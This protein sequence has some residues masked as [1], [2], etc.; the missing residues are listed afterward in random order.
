ML[1]V[2]QLKCRVSTIDDLRLYLIPQLGSIVAPGIQTS[3]NP[4]R[5]YETFSSILLH[6]QRDSEKSRAGTEIDVETS[7]L[8]R[9]V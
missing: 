8:D 7:T 4:S 3:A 2:K 9:P 6:P 1:L 5:M